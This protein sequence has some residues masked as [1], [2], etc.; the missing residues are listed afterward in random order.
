MQVSAQ[1]QGDANPRTRGRDASVSIR[2]TVVV[3]VDGDDVARRVSQAIGGAAIRLGI[4]AVGGAATSRLAQCLAD[5]G[6][7]VNPGAGRG[8]LPGAAANWQSRP[9]PVS[10]TKQVERPLTK[11]T[12]PR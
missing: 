3:L 5:G 1:F 7:L 9:K 11:K 6:T 4:D 12:M 2:N 8:R 10:H